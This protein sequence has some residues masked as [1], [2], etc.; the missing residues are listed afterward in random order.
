MNNINKEQAK[1]YASDI[2]AQA[3]IVDDYQIVIVTFHDKSTKDFAYFV[4]RAKKNAPR[5][6]WEFLWSS[7]ASRSSE[8]GKYVEKLSFWVFANNLAS[9]RSGGKMAFVNV[10]YLQDPGYVFERVNMLMQEWSRKLPMFQFK[11]RFY[12][13]ERDRSLDTL[14]QDPDRVAVYL[15]MCPECS[16]FH[17]VAHFPSGKIM[18]KDVQDLKNNPGL[19]YLYHQSGTFYFGYNSERR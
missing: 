7:A 15:D 18:C 5:S 16:N 3:T 14:P 12:V 2:L 13:Q 1:A 19:H 11:G 8:R 10:K 4:S 17:R 9:A 6:E